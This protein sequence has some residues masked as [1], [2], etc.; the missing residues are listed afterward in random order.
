MIHGPV[1]T[2]VMYLLYIL[3]PSLSVCLPVSDHQNFV[4]LPYG[5]RLKIDLI[6]N[7]TLVRLYYSRSDDTSHLLL[8][9][10]GFTVVTGASYY[11]LLSHHCCVF[12]W[13][14]LFHVKRLRIK[15]KCQIF[16]IEC[17]AK[18]KNKSEEGDHFKS[19]VEEPSSEGTQNVLRFLQWSFNKHQSWTSI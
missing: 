15:L 17:Q 11:F 10:G 16:R 19:P 18:E 7:R 5:K 8:D 13:F 12:A 1:K 14:L 4:T 6:L 9:K 3:P 2:A